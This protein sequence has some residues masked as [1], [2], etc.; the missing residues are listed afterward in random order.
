M[1][2]FDRTSFA[3]TTTKSHNDWENSC[4]GHI[5]FKHGGRWF[6]FVSPS[7]IS[8]YLRPRS[9]KSVLLNFCLPSSAI[10][11]SSWPPCRSPTVTL[12]HPKKKTSMLAAGGINWKTYLCERLQ[13]KNKTKNKH[14]HTQSSSQHNSSQCCCTVIWAAQPGSCIVNGNSKICAWCHLSPQQPHSSVTTTGSSC[15]PQGP[16]KAFLF[17]HFIG[18]GKAISY[19]RNIRHT[20]IWIST[21]AGNSRWRWDFHGSTR[22]NNTYILYIHGQRLRFK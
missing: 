21:Y 20:W 15:Y 14:T 1:S 18:N 17:C 10:V 5:L 2:R 4:L 7:H 19:T 9:C 22:L 16:V 8:T 13:Q 11:Q 6:V 12:K 3:A